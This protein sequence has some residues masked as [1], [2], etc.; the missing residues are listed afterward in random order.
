M[1]CS[2]FRLVRSGSSR[3]L[4]FLTAAAAAAAAV[5]AAA[6]AAAAAVAA[7]AGVRWIAMWA[8]YP[9]WSSGVN[10]DFSAILVCVWQSFLFTALSYPSLSGFRASTPF[11]P[12]GGFRTA[13]FARTQIFLAH[14]VRVGIARGRVYFSRVHTIMFG[15]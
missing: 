14:W 9:A 15:W 10:P 5:A 7:V 6:A 1:I 11:S 8:S 3:G 13:A 4:F 2:V 12:L